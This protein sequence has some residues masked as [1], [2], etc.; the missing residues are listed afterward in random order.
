MMD[1]RT[2]FYRR[3]LF[4]PSYFR[5]IGILIIWNFSLKGN[6]VIHHATMLRYMMQQSCYHFQILL[7]ILFYVN[8][9]VICQ[10]I[11]K[12]IQNKMHLFAVFTLTQGLTDNEVGSFLHLD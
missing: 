3:I 10:E 6:D 7:T 8:V 12:T 9:T 4:I 11:A 2:H 5:V 1:F